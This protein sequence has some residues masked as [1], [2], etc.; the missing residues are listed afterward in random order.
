MRG[1]TK[2]QACAKEIEI[3]KQHKAN[4][5][6]YGY[7][8]SAGGEFALDGVPRTKE[9]GQNISKGKR[10]TKHPLHGKRL[11]KEHRRKISKSN[12]GKHGPPY[13]AIEARR[14]PVLKMTMDG[15]ILERYPST[16]QAEAANKC[17]HIA[18]V[19]NGKRGHSAGYKWKYVK[20]V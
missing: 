2:S 13:K 17:S 3:I 9:W 15:E 1:L 5:P 12:I 19:C 20:E 7:N 14:K 8:R 6:E 11:T 10:G 4:N 18:D 16:R